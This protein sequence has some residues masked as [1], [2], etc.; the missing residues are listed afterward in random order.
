MNEILEKLSR[1]KKKDKFSDSELD[2]RGLNPSDVELCSKMEGL[3]NDCADSL[4]LLRAIKT[5]AQIKI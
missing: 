5:S 1:F 3:F 2:K 4:I